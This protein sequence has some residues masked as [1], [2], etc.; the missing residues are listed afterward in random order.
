M[1]LVF[2]I[3]ITCESKV[4]VGEAFNFSVSF[5]SKLNVISSIDFGDNESRV[6]QLFNGMNVVSKVYE[7]VGKYNI[8]VK[9]IDLDYE[10]YFTIDGKPGLYFFNFILKIRKSVTNKNLLFK[11]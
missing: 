9:A 8:L 2:E 4:L 6:F 5:N 3:N 11:N 10:S 1:L 7:T